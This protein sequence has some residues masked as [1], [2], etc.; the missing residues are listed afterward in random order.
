MLS[1]FLSSSNKF[2]MSKFENLEIGNILNQLKSESILSNLF[3]C[4]FDF[5][6]E[7]Q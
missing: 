1:K 7:S 4:L 6:S 5:V 3:I 2:A